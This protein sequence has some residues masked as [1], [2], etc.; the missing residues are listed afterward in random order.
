MAFTGK[1]NSCRTL[2]PPRP[3]TPLPPPPHDSTS[4]S[5]G[6]SPLLRE[7]VALRPPPPHPIRPR[8]ERFQAALRRAPRK[9]PRH[10][11][12]PL[13]RIGE[14][15]DTPASSTQ[16]PLQPTLRGLPGQREQKIAFLFPG[17]SPPPQ[18]LPF[19]AA[20]RPGVPGKQ[21]ASPPAPATRTRRGTAG[22]GAAAAA[23]PGTRLTGSCAKAI[24]IS[25]APQRVSN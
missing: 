11:G 6:L 16:T 18:R 12:L 3:P 8:R 19:P 10:S 22:S 2:S 24:N 4:P 20:A 14:K 15:G 9:P 21:A 23:G 7:R 1:H 5:L 17:G 25:E 13:P